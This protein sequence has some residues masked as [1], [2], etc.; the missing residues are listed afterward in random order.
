MITVQSCWTKPFYNSLLN[1]AQVQILGS[2]G[3]P[4]CGWLRIPK[5]AGYDCLAPFFTSLMHMNCFQAP[6]PM[7]MSILVCSEAS[8]CLLIK[9]ILV[10][11]TG[12]PA[13]KGRKREEDLKSA[14]SV[15]QTWSA[16]L[17]Q[18]IKN[19]AAPLDF[20]VLWNNIFSHFFFPCEWIKQKV[21]FPH[22]RRWKRKQSV[23][24][25]GGTLH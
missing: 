8:H 22:S 16:L 21:L 18:V 11:D 9:L 7:L 6:L 25:N 10:K 3:S 12:K 2:L 24:F 23:Q 4:A 5:L 17:D 1:S 14:A 20:F 15:S 13:L 19:D